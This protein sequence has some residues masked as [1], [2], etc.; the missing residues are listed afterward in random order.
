MVFVGVVTWLYVFALLF[1]YLFDLHS[2]YRILFVV[3]RGR[4]RFPP[5]NCPMAPSCTLIPL[6]GRSLR[7][8][9]PHA[10][11]PTPD[12]ARFS[13]LCECTDTPAV[14]CAGRSSPSTC[15]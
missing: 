3:V 8:P 2:K 15:C 13:L 5:S 1:F 14:L 10:R 4:P 9:P 7:A 6:R 12:D 11:T